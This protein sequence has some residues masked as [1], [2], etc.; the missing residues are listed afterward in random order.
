MTEEGWGPPDGAV[1]G[2]KGYPWITG[3]A[4]GLIAAPAMTRPGTGPLGL[5]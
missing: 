5:R 2:C 3:P 1:W 4:G